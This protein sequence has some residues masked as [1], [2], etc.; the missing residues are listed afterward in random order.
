MVATSIS[1]RRG[2]PRNLTGNSLVRNRALFHRAGFAT[3]LVDAPSDHHKRDGLGGFRIEPEHAADIG[4]VIADLRDRTGRPVW[5][6][7]N[8]RG[9]I[10]AVN[11]AVRLD[12]LAAPDGLVLTSPLTLG[13]KRAYKQWVTQSV[14]SVELA[15]IRMPVLV[16]VHG[17]DKCIRTP[18]E[19]AGQIAAKTNG[20]REQTVT[21]AGGPGW[22]GGPSVKSCIGKSPHGFVEQE[23]DVVAGVARFVRGGTF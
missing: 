11:A 23:A 6:V 20:S 16:V 10:S 13:R 4:T 17:A 9:S 21:V 14:F 15:A 2:C 19:I 1:T 22:A 3:A 18:P 7:G 8:S 12:G 5:L